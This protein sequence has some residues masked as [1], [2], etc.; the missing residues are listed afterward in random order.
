MNK[1][2]YITI[3]SFCIYTNHTFSQDFD[4]SFLESLP[5]EVAEEIKEKA[6]K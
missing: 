4:E 1:T 6:E 2:L 5:K 3:L